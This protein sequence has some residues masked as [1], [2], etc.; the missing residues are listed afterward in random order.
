LAKAESSGE[1]GYV[2]VNFLLPTPIANEPN[3]DT[4]TALADPSAPVVVAAAALRPYPWFRGVVPREQSEL[5]LSK[6]PAGGFLV[7]ESTAKP[8]MFSLSVK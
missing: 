1:S 5:L 3:D 2:P 4:A 6:A 7:R 8:G